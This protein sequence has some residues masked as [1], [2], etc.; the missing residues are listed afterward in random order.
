MTRV[1]HNK[2]TFDFVVN[3]FKKEGCELLEKEYKNSSTKMKYI[4]GCGNKSEISY[5]NFKT[6][7]RCMSCAIIKRTERRRTAYSEVEKIFKERGCELL[8]K[9]YKNNRIPLKYICKCGRKA[10]TTL[11]N[12][13]KSNGCMRCRGDR[14]RRSKALGIEKARNIFEEGG[15]LLLEKEYTNARTPMLYVCNCGSISKIRLDNFRKGKRCREC[16]LEKNRGEN[17]TRY[18]SDMT[19]EERMESRNYPQYREWRK[20]VY[21]RDDYTCQ[22]CKERGGE[23]HAHHLYSYSQH[24]DKRVCIDNGI[25]LCAGCHTE[26]HATYG[27]W[28]NTKSQYEEWNNVCKR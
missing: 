27:M 17:N 8:S 6:G 22:K 4:C 23:L 18:N 21:E 2:L 20:S 15:C 13:K 1:A 3:E 25:T 16:G 10:E 5:D 24:P 26:F 28:G 12:F 9:E 14:T 11:G 7:H 19:E